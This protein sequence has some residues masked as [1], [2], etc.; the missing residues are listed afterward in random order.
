[1][2]ADALRDELRGAN[3]NRAILCYLVFDEMRKVVGEE[4][5]TAVMKRAIYRRGGGDVR[6]HPAVRT[7]SHP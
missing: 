5:A 4:E 2:D 7:R 3:A 6:I 1:M